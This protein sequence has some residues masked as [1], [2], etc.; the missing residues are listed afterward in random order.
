MDSWAE[1]ADFINWLKPD[2]TSL[3]SLVKI[4]SSQKTH[5]SE[6]SKISMIVVKIIFQYPYEIKA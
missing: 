6:N 1:F 4:Y 2:Q 5:G 3:L